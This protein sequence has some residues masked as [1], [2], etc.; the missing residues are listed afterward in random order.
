M[1]ADGTIDQLAIEVTGDAE[2]AVRTLG[3]LAE[4]LATLERRLPAS[5]SKTLEFNAAIAALSRSLAG[6]DTSKLRD[7]GTVKL[8]AATAKN[9]AS[10]VG[11]IRS[12]PEDAVT[13]MQ[14]VATALGSLRGVSLT[15]GTVDA[16]ARIPSVLREFEG[17]DMG[18]FGAQIAELNPRITELAGN[19]TKLATAYKSLPKSMQTAGLAA[20]SVA[21]SNK[22]LS[23]V[24]K[25][26][27]GSSKKAKVSVSGLGSAM[28]KAF[29]FAGLA[30]G[31]YT[32]KR[33][34]EATVGAVNTYIED[35]N[36]FNA[37]MGQYADEASAYAKKVSEALGIDMGEWVKYTGVF[38]NLSTSFGIA[39]DRSATMSRNLTQL[40]YDLAS[41]HNMDLDQMM[42]KIQSGLAGEIEPM[43]RIGVDL[44]NAAMQAEAT[45]LGIT[46]LVSDMDQAEKAALRY[47]LM[48]KGTTV[49]QGDMARTIASPA[50]QLRVLKAQFQ[51]AARAI[52]NLFIPALNAILPVVIAVTKAITLLA[53]TIANFFGIDAT[54]EVD[55]SGLTGGASYDTGGI[56]DVTDSLD[57]SGDAAEKARKK[58][59]EYQNTVMGF[60]ELN[61]LNAT[62]E[63]SDSDGSGAADDLDGAGGSVLADIPLDTY[64]FLKG[65]TDDISAMTDEM[66]QSILSLLPHIAAV[67]AGL[68][69][70]RVASAL[71]LDLA[72]IA[73]LAIAVAGAVELATGAFDAWTNGLDWGNLLQ[74]LGGAALLATGLGLAFGEVGAEVGL[75]V[76]GLTVFVVSIHDAIESG[77][78]E[79]NRFGA[80]AGVGLAALGTIL[81]GLSPVV[82]GVVATV[83]GAVMAVMGF[84]DAWQQGLGLEN[85]KWYLEG[86]AV[87]VA[88]LLTAFGPVGAVI[89]GVVAGIGALVLGLKDMWENGFSPESFAMTELGFTGIGVAIGALFG[90]VGA[91]V[92]A[93]IGAFAGLIATLVTD[94]E[95]FS[96]WMGELW[97]GIV[98]ATRGIWEPVAT[99]FDQSVV[100]PVTTLFAAVS[101]FFEGLW[102][103]IVTGISNWWGGVAQWMNDNVVQPIVDFWSPMADWFSRLWSS[104]SATAEAVWHN[105]GVLIQGVWEVVQRCW[106]VAGDWFEGTVL[107][108]VHDWFARRW[109]EISDAVGNAWESA[110]RI[111]SVA[112]GWFD[113]N[114]IQPILGGFSRAWDDAVA[115]AQE[116][117]D[118]ISGAF[119][120]F[121]SFFGGIVSDAWER[122]RS[123]FEWGGNIFEGV[124]D[125]ILDAFKAVM[126][127]FIGGL[128]WAIAQP[129]EGLNSI[130]AAMRGWEILGIR[131][132]SGFWDV[133]VPQIPYFAEGRY[134]IDAG[135]L[136]VARERG[137]ELVGTMGG[138]TTVAN[139]QQIVEGIEAG[140]FSGVLRA[141]AMGGGG[142]Q[143][144]ETT[145]EIP[146]YFGD[147]EVARA[148]WRGEL[149]LV[150]RGVL[151]PQF[152]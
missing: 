58:V 85:I 60:D 103:G 8:N 44:S 69:A 104:V 117:W 105:I 123:A 26:L 47:R 87:A 67:A 107:R 108:P 126:N 140:V 94:W 32:L 75:V 91:L 2:Q 10:L 39:A 110:K 84:M 16:I 112:W 46:K 62:P 5:A 64:D 139:N 92:G 13:R 65:L 33:A 73:G 144:G 95:G 88:G 124:V 77:L 51:M 146:V 120:D 128:N 23:Q 121:G 34:F 4:R 17:L 61:K 50:N 20:R 15:K 149:S 1:A 28:R 114:V 6:L 22:Y 138:K 45:S 119:A 136:F 42:L 80:A 152:A 31:W 19:V 147:E 11:S 54:F 134:G 38:Q 27:D 129:F 135:Q 48:L 141:L 14:G 7:L 68:A 143:S 122:I 148:S 49:A 21:A 76:G 78:G 90:P 98:D 9:V 132:F 53:Q 142:S 56:D 82:T 116:A 71:G 40:G 99:W 72:K 133:P 111:W 63:D 100:Q 89:G 93:I 118:R 3:R 106:E 70:W 101:P 41:F 30:A 59:R 86:V 130:L 35:M 83:G 55:Y 37:S 74:M 151:K 137:P 97:A 81:A 29:N 36:L 25:E 150:R 52:G 79:V 96:A 18:A 145:I 12:M 125:A 102:N 113:A 109:Q 127:E 24:N 131:P 57:D 43:R 115:G 66:A